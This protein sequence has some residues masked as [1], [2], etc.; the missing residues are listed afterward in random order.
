MT[1]GID[2]RV[3]K[4]KDKEEMKEKEEEDRHH[5]MDNKMEVDVIHAMVDI[6][7]LSQ[8]L[9]PRPYDVVA[10][11]A[12]EAAE[13][14]EEVVV[15]VVAVVVAL[16]PALEDLEAASPTLHVIVRIIPQSLLRQ[17]PKKLNSHV[18]KNLH[19]SV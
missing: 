8:M 19:V 10:V 17:L 12:E 2:Q 16:A 9:S 6:A 13:E 5:G 7:E 1:E 18:K 14:A 4:E 11:V 3:D 15:A